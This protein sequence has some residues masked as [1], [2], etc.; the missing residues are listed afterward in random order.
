MFWSNLLYSNHIWNTM[1]RSIRYSSKRDSE[2]FV[3]EK[4]YQ[5]GEIPGKQTLCKGY[6]L[7]LACRNDSRN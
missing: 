3:L 4:G 1:C 5:N 7:T 2:K 6:G